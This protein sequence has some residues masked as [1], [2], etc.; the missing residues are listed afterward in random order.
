[1]RHFYLDASAVVKRYN[2]E[3]DS[4][5][6]TAPASMASAGGNQNM[7]ST[8]RYSSMVAESSA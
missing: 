1:V 4:F 6:S 5:D 2:L 7:I 3:T 8:A